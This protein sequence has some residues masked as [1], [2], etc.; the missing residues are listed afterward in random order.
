[1]NWFTSPI[2]I[3]KVSTSFDY[4][5]RLKRLDT[6]LCNP[7]NQNS[8]KVPKVYNPTNKKTLDT[9]VKKSPMSPPS[10]SLCNKKSC[11][12][13]KLSIGPRKALTGILGSSILQR[14]IVMAKIINDWTCKKCN[15]T[16]QFYIYDTFLFT[17]FFV[18]W[19]DGRTDLES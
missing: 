12:T 17:Q 8:A 5:Y 13:A 4:Y 2:I 1:M 15:I 16:L 18:T 6:Q 9:R 19:R 14:L 10:L 11:L 3:H 7:T